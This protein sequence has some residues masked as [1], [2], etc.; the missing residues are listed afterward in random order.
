MNDSWLTKDHIDL[1][2]EKPHMLDHMIRQSKLTD[3]HSKWIKYIWVANKDRSLQAHRNSFKTT[4]ILVIGSI[5]W[6]LF[7]PND[8]IFIIRKSFTDA[9]D[10]IA[11]ICALMDT[12]EMKAL[13]T[14]LHGIPLDYK[15]KRAGQVNFTFKQ[16]VTVEYNLNAIGINQ[17]VT[18]KHCDKALCDDFVDLKDRTSPA[19]RKKT[20]SHIREIQTNIIESNPGKTCGFIGTPWHKQDAWTVCPE[21]V[22]FDVYSCGIFSDEQIEDKRSKTTHSLFAANY[23]LK[24]LSEEGKLFKDPGECKWSYSVLSPYAHLDAA[25]GGKDTCA[26]S[27]FA[28]IRNKDKIQ[29]LGRIFPGN[30]KDWID[31]I[32][33]EYRKRRC[34]GIWV[35]KNTDKEYAADLLKGRGLVVHSYDE[36]M[37]KHI[38]ISTYL[39]HEWNNILWDVE[40]D[41]EYLNQILDYE[42]GEEPDDAPDSAASLIQKKFYR[43][44]EKDGLWTF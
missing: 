33:A 34:K 37:N 25:Y 30:V 38:K 1:I 7:H 19:E 42:K 13:F 20:I 10:V 41:P 22:K 18:G 3:L 17:S 31:F 9:C 8:R 44:K 32:E 16:N 27:I 35:E 26:L 14:Y 11:A 40:T 29:G 36:S 2:L 21:P 5:W 23:E 28:K 24:H 12:P 39:Y 6:L 4:A 43:P 15:T